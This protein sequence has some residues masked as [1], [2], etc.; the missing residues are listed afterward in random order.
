MPSKKLRAALWVI[1]VL[2]A[3]VAAFSWFGLNYMHKG[4][5]PFF[6]LYHFLW[7]NEH[8]WQPLQFVG[9]AISFGVLLTLFGFRIIQ[10]RSKTQPTW[11]K[12]HKFNQMRAVALIIAGIPGLVLVP[13]GIG[14]LTMF[15]PDTNIRNTIGGL[16]LMVSVGLLIP[17]SFAMFTLLILNFINWS[18]RTVDPEA[19]TPRVQTVQILLAVIAAAMPPIA[20]FAMLNTAFTECVTAC[21]AFNV[22]EILPAAA[23]YVATWIALGIIWLKTRNPK[24]T[25]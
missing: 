1:A 9:V 25:A 19:P 3:A 23:V 2:S 17:S 14:S 22:P 15:L 11:T 8:L 4:G 24:P 6:P 18:R 20:Y 10:N 21:S 12:H 13:F 16:L 5:E 7:D